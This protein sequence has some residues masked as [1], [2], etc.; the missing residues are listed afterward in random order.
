LN[1]NLKQILNFIFNVIK[2]TREVHGLWKDY[3]KFPKDL[4]DSLG[5]PPI[6]G[7]WHYHYENKNG[8][9]GL[10]RLNHGLELSIKNGKWRGHCYEA[11]GKLD[12]KQF[13]TK[14]QAEIAIYKALDESYD[15]V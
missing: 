9:I 13:K 6:V 7:K 1:H 10:V 12:F 5:M 14:K 3:S 11:C 2:E 15:Q 8:R 4:R